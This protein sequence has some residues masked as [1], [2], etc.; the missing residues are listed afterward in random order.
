VENLT[1]IYDTGNNAKKNQALGDQAP[2]HDVASL[3]P[4]Q[5]KELMAIAATKY[6][7]LGPGP[8]EG[9]QVYR[10][11]RELWGVERTVV[12]F[13]S[14]QLRAGQI[15]G[16]NQQLHKR[17]KALEA[18]K[19]RLSKPRSGPRTPQKGHQ[20]AQSLQRGQ[21][22]SDILKIQYHPWRKGAHRL[23]WFIEETARAHLYNEVCGKRILMTDQHEWSSEEIMLAYRGQSRAEAAFR[24]LKAPM[25]LAVR[26][27]YHWS[28]QKVRVH[29]FI[30]L[31][32]LLLS[33]LIE[34]EARQ[35]GYHGSLSGLLDQLASIRL[36]MV[37]RPA[38]EKGGRPRC[39]WTLE[40]HSDSVQRIFQRIVPQKVPFV[41]TPLSTGNPDPT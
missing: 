12:L 18:W 29:A 4:S 2:F 41:Y 30:C 17:L 10:C 3:V 1:V 26:P 21:Y 28:E 6:T 7:P 34:R 8:L 32:A 11:H 37:L 25:H 35:A 19:Q 15:R 5:H 13:I 40:D 38:R 36:A 14:P 16:V 31:I 23:S 24:Q 39:E 9:M 33:R 22:I 27:P 20:Q